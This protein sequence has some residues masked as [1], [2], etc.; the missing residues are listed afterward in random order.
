[1]TRVGFEP[2]RVSSVEANYAG[3]LA[4]ESTALDRSAISPE[5][6]SENWHYYLQGSQNSSYKFPYKEL[7]L[8]KFPL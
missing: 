8:V 5:F 3:K 6:Q 1:M 7:Y 4:L 2:T